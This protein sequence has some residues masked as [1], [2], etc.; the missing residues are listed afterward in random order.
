[1]DGKYTTYSRIGISDDSIYTHK[2][3]MCVCPC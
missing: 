1:M 2:Y 3:Y